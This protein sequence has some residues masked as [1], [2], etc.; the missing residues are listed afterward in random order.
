[1]ERLVKSMASSLL[2]RAKNTIER[3]KTRGLR[4][5]RENQQTTALVV[6]G[7]AG[8]GVTVAAAFADQKMGAGKQWKVGP[9][10][11]TAI[12]GVAALVPAFFLKKEPIAMA[13]AVSAG[14]TL[15]NISLYAFLRE[16]V[17]E[18]GEE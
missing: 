15:L 1:M 2:L 6:G 18:P 16:E 17:I 3:A 8:T 7:L 13:A 5:A 14:A 12:G 11:V 4:A 10:P 9:V